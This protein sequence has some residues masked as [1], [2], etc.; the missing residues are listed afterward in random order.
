MKKASN[1]LVSL[2]ITLVLSA[3][4]YGVFAEDKLEAPP[5]GP[6]N[7]GFDKMVQNLSEQGFDVSIIQAAIDSGDNDTARILLDE[8]YVAHPEAKPKRPEMNVEQLG[9]IIQELKEKEKDVA[10]IEAALAD[11]NVNDAQVLLNEFW[12]NNPDERPAPPNQGEKTP[13]E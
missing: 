13:R 11:G 10:S 2:I 12:K 7:G 5:N 9:K 6:P 8:F 4:V 1:I 3:M